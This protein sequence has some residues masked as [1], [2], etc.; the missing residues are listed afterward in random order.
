[1]ARVLCFDAFGTLFDTDSVRH[2]LRERLDAPAGI[3]DAV[4]ARWRDKQLSYSYQLALMGDYRPFSAVTD[5]ALDYALAYHGF[6]PSALDVDAVMGAYEALDPFDDVAPTLDRLADDG[7][8]LAVLS[9]G[10]PALLEAVVENAGLADRFEAVV[11]ADEVETFKPAPA[12][13]ERA[14]ERLDAPLGECWLVSSNA[15]DAAGAAHAGMGVAWVNRS[16]D[17]P[18]RIGGEPDL[19]VPSLPPLVDALG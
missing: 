13:Y 17:P 4:V 2:R 3:V 14:A 7:H 5:D 1:M 16:A 15:W 18:E 19:E 6:H 8:R 9:N 10:D 12:V 11:S